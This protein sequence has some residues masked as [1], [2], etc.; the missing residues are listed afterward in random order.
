MFDSIILPKIIGN[1]EWSEA[2]QLLE[3]NYDLSIDES[4]KLFCVKY[5]HDS[6]LWTRGT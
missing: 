1:L 2:R 3:R 4:D 5:N 6:H